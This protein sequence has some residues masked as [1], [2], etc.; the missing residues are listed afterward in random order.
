MTFAEIVNIGLEQLGLMPD[1]TL[2]L[3]PLVLNG[4][5]KRKRMD[6]ALRWEHTRWLGTVLRNH[7]FG[8]KKAIKPVEM[9]RIPEIDGSLAPIEPVS[10]LDLSKI[11]KELQE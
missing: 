8:Q 3:T 5:L 11:W 10:D 6:A 9:F 2:A 1:E 4:L 7:A